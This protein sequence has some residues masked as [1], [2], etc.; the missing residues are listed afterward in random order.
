MVFTAVSGLSKMV[1]AGNTCCYGQNSQMAPGSLPP[2]VR[3]IIRLPCMESV[4]DFSDVIGVP[5]QLTLRCQKG[6][7]SGWSRF[8]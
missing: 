2:G 7:Y 1:L 6:D 5:N 8:S 3:T 4:M